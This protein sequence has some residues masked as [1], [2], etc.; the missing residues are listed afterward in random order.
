MAAAKQTFGKP[1]VTALQEYCAKNNIP[2][3]TYDW[4][5]SDDGSFVCKVDAV[6]SRE[7]GYG[8][9]KREAKHDAAANII[10]KLKLTHPD[11]TDIPQAPHEAIPTTDIIV[12]LR[13]YCVQ[14]NHPLPTIEIIQQTGPAEAPEFTAVCVL[15]TIK[16][17]GVANNKKEARQK[18]ALEMLR[19][20][21]DVRTYL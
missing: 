16:R 4:I 5:D 9:S 2:L 21:I 6:D 15:S 17:Y 13:D 3:P 14:R 12:K 10:K 20:I 8:R 1:P 18:A 11:I 7:H 19:V